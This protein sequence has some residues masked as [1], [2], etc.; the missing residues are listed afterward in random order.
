MSE[1]KKQDK[2]VTLYLGEDRDNRTK[3]GYELNNTMIIGTSG[4]GKSTMLNGIITDT[5]QNYS[6]NNVGLFLI[7]PKGCEF[8]NYTKIGRVPKHVEGYASIE[9][10]I[11]KLLKDIHEFALGRL[12]LDNYDKQYIIF[13]DEF[14]F[15]TEGM[16]E[17]CDILKKIINI[18]EQSEVYV[19]MASQ[20]VTE[21]ST[22][23]ISDFPIR[24]AL[25]MNSSQMDLANR[26]MECVAPVNEEQ[27]AGIV[28]V[29]DYNKV[30]D[31]K[32]LHVKFRP[33]TYIRKIL[34]L[35]GK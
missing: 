18:S 17:C 5:I 26:Y 12:F 28:Y 31:I 21:S 15:I 3:V 16:P 20:S 8:Y 29:R 1:I 27:K 2:K 10:D 23:R 13:I 11:I 34:K 7:D 22:I 6:H 32:R 24:C 35:Y 25:R 14:Q 4:A 33:D 30:F 19:V 9:E